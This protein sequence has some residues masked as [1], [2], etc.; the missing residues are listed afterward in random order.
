MINLFRPLHQW[1]ASIYCHRVADDSYN[2]V[3]TIILC[4]WVPNLIFGF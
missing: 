2:T 1:K 3:L 4:F